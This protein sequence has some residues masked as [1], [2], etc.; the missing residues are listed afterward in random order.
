MPRTSSCLSSING[1]YEMDATPIS[2]FALDGSLLIPIGKSY[3][4]HAVE[5]AKLFQA[6]KDKLC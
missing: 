5:E 2:M 3:I 4:I 1:N 6:G